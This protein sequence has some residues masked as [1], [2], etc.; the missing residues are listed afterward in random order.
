VDGRAK[1]GQ[2]EEHGCNSTFHLISP[3][4]P[5]TGKG[6]EGVSAVQSGRKRR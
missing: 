4:L 1:P 3:A 6:W 5:V 2:D